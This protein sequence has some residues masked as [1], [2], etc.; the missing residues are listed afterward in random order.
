MPQI[1]PWLGGLLDAPALLRQCLAL[2]A[3]RISTHAPLLFRHSR[4]RPLHPGRRRMS[5][6]AVNA[7]EHE[8]QLKPPPRSDA[9]CCQRAWPV[10]SRSRSET[11]PRRDGDGDTGGRPRGP[12]ARRPETMHAADLCHIQTETLPGR[13]HRAFKRWK[14]AF[15]VTVGKIGLAPP[16]AAFEWAEPAFELFIPVLVGLE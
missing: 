8:A 3:E 9:T 7:A 2:A 11:R 12:G 6:P 14:A 4:R 16:L 5:S 10:P 15:A 13:S 1:H